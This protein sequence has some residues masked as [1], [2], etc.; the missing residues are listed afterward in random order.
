VEGSKKY[1]QVKGN[2]NYSNSTLAVEDKMLIKDL[3]E[4]VPVGEGG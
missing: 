2:T 4:K 1:L 3:M